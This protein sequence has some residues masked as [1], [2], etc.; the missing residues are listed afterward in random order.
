LAFSS[1]ATVLYLSTDGSGQPLDVAAFAF[2]TAGPSGV[3]L[4]NILNNIAFSAF[5][6]SWAFFVPGN[7]TITSIAA[8]FSLSTTI[9]IPLTSVVTVFAQ[10]YASTSM[11]P[12]FIATDYFPVPGASVTMTSTFSGTVSPGILIYGF[13]TGLTIPISAP[14]SLIMVYSITANFPQLAVTISGY[15]SASITFST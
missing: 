4:N 6:G 1:G 5:N 9:T 3:T 8:S 15:G 13:A 2:G 12:S 10:L 7:I 11:S 14:S